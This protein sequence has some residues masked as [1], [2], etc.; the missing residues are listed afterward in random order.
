M[1]TIL[2]ARDAKIQ[3][4]RYIAQALNE[5]TTWRVIRQIKKIRNGILHTSLN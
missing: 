2:S 1:I 5:L 4:I 3:N